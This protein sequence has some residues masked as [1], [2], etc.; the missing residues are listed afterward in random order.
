MSGAFTPRRRAGR[1]ILSS[2]RLAL[3]KRPRPLG[4][5]RRRWVNARRDRAGSMARRPRTDGRGQPAGSHETAL[6]PRAFCALPS[7][8]RAPDGP[9]AQWLEP[10]AHNGLVAG[11][12]PARPTSTPRFCRTLRLLGRAS[13]RQQRFHVHQSRPDGRA[14]TSCRSTG[15]G[16]VGHRLTLARSIATSIS[17]DKVARAPPALAHLLC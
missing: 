7:G 3:R 2:A 4:G 10:A 12:S 16:I 13:Q 6:P 17:P 8:R 9:V 1:F 11:S 14:L 5:R 15:T